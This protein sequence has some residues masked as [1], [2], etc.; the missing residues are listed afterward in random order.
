MRFDLEFQLIYEFLC[1]LWPEFEPQC[2]QLFAWGHIPILEV[3]SEITAKETRLCGAGLLAI[4][5]ILVARAPAAHAP[6]SY[7]ALPLLPTPPGR[8]GHP[9]R[10][11]GNPRSGPRCGYCHKHGHPETN[12]FKKQLHLC[13]GTLTTSTAACALASVPSTTDF[14]EQD[15]VRLWRLLASSGSSSTGT[16]AS[17]TATPTQSGKSS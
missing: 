15:I 4:L 11:R 6:T 9:F 13:N 16:A 14:T 10:G 12:C 1:R 3:R 5:S 8:G 2:S 17:V 7:S